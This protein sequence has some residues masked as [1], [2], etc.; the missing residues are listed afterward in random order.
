VNFG[1]STTFNKAVLTEYD[2]RTTGYRIEYWNG[3]SWATA[4]VGTTIGASYVPKT[5]TFPAVTGNKARLYFTSGTANA[6]I[7]YEFAIY[8]DTSNLA[9]SKTYAG[10]SSWDGTQTAD[11]AFDGTTSTNWQACSGCWSGQTLE[12][13][14]G[15]SASFNKAVLTEYDNRTTGYRIEYWNG[16]AWATAY[17]GTTIGASYVPKT[18][19]FPAVTG[20]KARL[21]FTSGT[22]FAP[23]IYEFEIYNH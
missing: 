14:F 18:V 8:N 12:V 1:A 2:S 13:N 3:S 7:I 9:L 10:S 16:S 17:T 20:S 22:S 19:T 23:I 4:Y 5:V 21:Y 15:A 6:P 11:K